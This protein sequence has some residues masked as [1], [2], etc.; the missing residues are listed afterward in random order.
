LS[1]R[2]Y[3]LISQLSSLFRSQPQPHTN[4]DEET[5]LS[6]RPSRPQVVEVAAVRDKQVCLYLVRVQ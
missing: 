4:S 1:S 2:P 5:A 6:Q 3:A